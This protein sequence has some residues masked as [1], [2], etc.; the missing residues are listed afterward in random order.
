[1]NIKEALKLCGKDS[2]RGRF[3]ADLVQV[4]G[5]SILDA[6]R[7]NDQKTLVLVASA[8]PDFAPLLKRIGAEAKAHP[9]LWYRQSDK[10]VSL[11]LQEPFEL[12]ILAADH[13]RLIFLLAQ[14]PNPV[15]AA[16]PDSV[17]PLVDVFLTTTTRCVQQFVK[18]YLER[19]LR[20]EGKAEL[21]QTIAECLPAK[22]KVSPWVF[23]GLNAAQVSALQ[24][25]KTLRTLSLTS[26]NFELEQ[27]LGHLFN[28][29]E[30]VQIF[31]EM[32]KERLRYDY[33]E[34]TLQSEL[35]PIENVSPNWVRNDTGYG[36]RLLSIILK[37]SFS[38]TLARRRLPV[39]I[40][41]EHCEEYIENPELLRIMSLNTGALTPLLLNGKSGG[42]LKIFFSGK[43]EFDAQLRDW[44]ST[45]GA[46]LMRGLYWASR[47]QEA[48]K[49]A[50][51]DGL[52]G[53]YNHRYFM[54]QLQKE[55]TRARRY[56]NWLSL[57]LIDIDYFKHYNDTNGHL[58]GDRVLMKVAKTIRASVREMDLVARWGGEEF[59]LLLPEISLENGMIVAEKIR[60]EVEVQRFANEQHQPGGLLT[61]SLGVAAN[62]PEL[63][64]YKEMFNK[65]DAVLYQAKQSGRNRCVP[66]KTGGSA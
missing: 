22:S 37:D 47:Y 33:L 10:L 41:Q 66:A 31:G 14:A 12:L 39:V 17:P 52:T 15:G 23:L 49:M 42:V 57:I 16:S 45:C 20:A 43:T 50:T 29:N 61:I 9:T 30:I 19:V 58:A 8:R 34:V 53:L 46:I 5:N 38:K 64:S 7:R 4:L 59:A 44:L 11:S 28:P 54:E 25:R 36:G 2:H 18:G 24:L 48:E 63:K 6:F 51:I 56:R 40:H 60:R 21:L 32:L 3:S 35:L 13:R 65:A 1:M 62:F 55:F 27:N 26:F